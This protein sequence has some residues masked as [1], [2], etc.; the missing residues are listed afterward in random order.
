MKRPFTLIELL[1]V[2]S[3]IAVLASLLLPALNQAR[4]HSRSIVCT[5]NLKQVMM[6]ALSYT[7]DYDDY[8]PPGDRA[9]TSGYD[10]GFPVFLQAYAANTTLSSHSGQYKSRVFVCPLDT[11]RWHLKV[12]SP[13][14]WDDLRQVSYHCNIN[15]WAASND[16]SWRDRLRSPLKLAAIR[17]KEGDTSDVAVITEQVN[18]SPPQLWD[19]SPRFELATI[20]GTNDSAPSLRTDFQVAH[21]N[22]RACNVAYLDGHTQILKW[23]SEFV[24]F[25]TFRYKFYQRPPG[26]SGW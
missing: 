4:Q 5:N 25:D 9:P 22:G 24:L 2:I 15:M 1:V 23:D 7:S 13:K 26:A 16:G 21:R 6:Y 18:G 3:I 12:D 14:G 19:N 11:N 20:W 17:P 10:V 8:L